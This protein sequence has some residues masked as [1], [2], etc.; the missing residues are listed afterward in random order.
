MYKT[1]FIEKF[2]RT[3]PEEPLAA[4][5]AHAQDDKLSYWSCCCLIGCINAPHALKGITIAPDGTA[6]TE[7][8]HLR[9]ARSM[10]FAEEAEYEFC[11]I[12]INLDYALSDALRRAVIIPLIRAEI[13]RRDKERSTSQTHIQDYQ[14][15]A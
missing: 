13:E 3:Y 8:T 2:L 15:V 11:A 9:E 6:F 14:P 10:P 4:L 7:Y 1:E 5:L 12:G